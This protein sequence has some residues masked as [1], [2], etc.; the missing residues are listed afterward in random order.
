MISANDARPIDCAEVIGIYNS[1][2]GSQYR[3]DDGEADPPL[4][5]QLAWPMRIGAGDDLPG[6]AQAPQ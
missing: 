2:T 5:Q 4:P 6:H 3:Q 1:G